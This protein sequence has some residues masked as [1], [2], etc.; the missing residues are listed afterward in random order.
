MLQ[1]GTVIGGRY[2]L[3]K[4]LGSGGMADVY[5]VNDDFLN[6]RV[7]MKV[8]PAELSRDKERVLRFEKEIRLSASLDHPHIATVYDVGQHEGLPYFTMALLPGGDLRD[9]IEA[10]LN[11][12][13]T[14]NII[15]QMA[16][17]LGFA[18]EHGLIHRDVKPSNVMFDARGRV[19]L[20]DFGIA[21]ATG[22]T[23]RLTKTGASIGT[24]KYMSP[25]QARAR[26]QMDG[27]SDL[28]SLGI[29]L[30]EMLMGRVPYEAE[31]SFATALCHIN[32]PLPVLPDHLARFQPLL[33]GVLAKDPTDRFYN[34]EAFIR[35]LK[36]IQ[37]DQAAEA[38]AFQ[39]KSAAVTGGGESEQ[40]ASAPSAS[41]SATPAPLESPRTAASIE[42]SRSP[43]PPVPPESSI[44][45]ESPVPPPESSM[46]PGSS[47]DPES[48]APPPTPTPPA[49]SRLADL[50]DIPSPEPTP[51]PEPP[52]PPESKGRAIPLWAPL[53]ALLLIVSLSLGG[54]FWYKAGKSPVET[55]EQI[56]STSEPPQTAPEPQAVDARVPTITAEPSIIPSEPQAVDSELS[57]TDSELPSPPDEAPA[58]IAGPPPTTTESPTV[59]PPAATGRLFVEPVPEDSTVELINIAERYKEGMELPPG[60]IH[61]RVEREG[62]VPQEEKIILAAG[63]EVRVQMR[64]DS[65]PTGTIVVEPTHPEAR[66][67]VDGSQVGTGSVEAQVT[68]GSR[69]VRVEFEGHKPFETRVELEAGGSVRVSALLEPEVTTG[70]LFVEPVPED[71][72]VK[73]MNIAPAYRAGMELEPGEYHIRV[74]KQ[75]YVTHNEKVMLA[76]GQELKMEIQLEQHAQTVAAQA[77]GTP[78][79]GAD[80]WIEPHTGMEFVRVPGGCFQMGCGPWTGE[81]YGAE[82][83]V[84]E[85]CVSGFWIGKYEVTQAQWEK[86]MG[87]NPS[88]FKGTGNPVE[89]VTWNDAQAFVKKLESLSP[90]SG[91]RLPREAEW[92]YACRGGGQKE[93]Y[94]GGNDINRVAWYDGNSGRKTRPV[95]GKA[96]NALGLYD[97]SGNVYEWCLDAWD[98]KAYSRSDRRQDPEV[99]GGTGVHRVYRG[100]SWYDMP[101][102]IRA[103]NRTKYIPNFKSSFVGLRVV[104]TP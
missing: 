24:P 37:V 28:Y 47:L 94:C 67:L 92:E 2:T 18:H 10:G 103:G 93:K 97:M 1:P 38:P 7:A 84:H 30:Y 75:G 61:I 3:I 87:S 51:T 41:P 104:R 53:L 29:V 56:I 81:C 16:D 71:A 25:E 70:R 98:E 59:E 13:E 27:R 52:R 49:H 48:P 96:P 35:A 12:D 60:E 45:P 26:I 31:D 86:V 102:N 32:D 9:K 82:K 62:Y 6:R 83:P 101:R 34:A 11:L 4:L 57:A 90:A 19:V 100:G 54:Y 36:K 89:N 76:A 79:Q 78:P 77:P 20:M 72:T 88:R 91:F 66:V 14:L 22:A 40:D 5:E 74:E 50:L 44:A 55:G 8:L 73:I 46:P 65:R 68:P 58:T 64:L 17:A 33:D 85:V 15:M 23:T 42:P 80:T 43:A 39:D 69:L 95:G 63:E 21:R 99:T